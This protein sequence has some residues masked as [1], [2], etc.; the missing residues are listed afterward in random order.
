MIDYGGKIVVLGFGS[1]GSG[2]MPLLLKHFSPDQI[3]VLGGD[4]RNQLIARELGITHRVQPLDR[5][6]YDAILSAE[7]GAGDFLVNLSVDVSSLA[8]ID[9]CRAHGA[10]Y[11]DTCIE[12]WAGYYTDTSIAPERRSNY[13]LRQDVLDRRADVGQAPATDLARRKN[14]STFDDDNTQSAVRFF[15]ALADVTKNSTDPRDAR[16]RAACD[17]SFS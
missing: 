16:V 13:S 1:I 10:L 4:D 2:L 6:N 5:S 11:L 7:L 9:W 12:P 15:L 17:P 8:L 14:T 3:L